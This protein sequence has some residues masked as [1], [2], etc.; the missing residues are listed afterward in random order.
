MHGHGNSGKSACSRRPAAHSERDAIRHSQSEGSLRSSILSEQLAIN[1]KDE[2]VF[3]VRT[4]HRIAARRVNRKFL[5]RLGI[6]F[7][8]E[9]E[10]YSRSIE[11][12][13]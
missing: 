11:P 12:R 4:T 7:E 5:R 9:I 2:I 8:E 3:Q 6:N 10:S 13:P 1:A